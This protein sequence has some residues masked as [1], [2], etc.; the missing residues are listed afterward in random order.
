MAPSREEMLADLKKVRIR[1]YIC[2]GASIGLPIL[3]AGLVITF[4]VRTP[5]HDIGSMILAGVAVIFTGIMINQ[6]IRAR[7]MEQ[8]INQRLSEAEAPAGAGTDE[9]PEGEK[10]PES[11]DDEDGPEHEGDG[12]GTDEP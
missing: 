4:F 5:V 7:Q 9:P 3:A 2:L 12:G 6:T 11:T 1:K 8:L 10:E